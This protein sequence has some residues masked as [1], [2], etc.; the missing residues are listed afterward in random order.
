[1]TDYQPIYE[2]TRG[3][4]RE[5][6][7][8]GAGV[9]VSADGR[10]L[11]HFGNPS[12]LTY[13]RSTAK[14]FQALP[15]VE[16]G[17]PAALSFST[18]ELALI[19]ASHHGTDDHAQTAAG[20]QSRVG[21]GETEL[22]CGVHP[23]VDAE[24]RAALRARGE[25][26]QLNRHNCSGKHTGML[27]YSTWQGWDNISYLD[28]Q[29][30][31]QKNILAAFAEMCAV[32]PGDVELGIDGCSAPNFAI[33]LY[34][35][36]L[37]LARLADPTDLED[38]RQTACRQITTAMMTHPEMIAGPKGFDTRL[39]QALGPILAAKGGA[40]GYQGLAILPGSRLGARGVGIAF[41]ISDG[42]ARGRNRAAVALEVLR[43]LDVINPDQLDSLSD[44][45]PEL[46]IE[47][48]RHLHVGRG[49][50]LISLVRDALD[51]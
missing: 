36:A 20:I 9:V 42:D 30:P 2:L 23:P 22:Q 44:F 3:H 40:E 49:R 33:P 10:L 16:A 31:V 7:H 51:A 25:D 29:H 48:W 17:G 15:F 35:A 26:P 39:M 4:V 14:P 12:A 13:L 32:E 38:S 11:A 47:N 45:G 34:N 19:C 41:K 8:F 43:Q 28:I 37:G 5:S 46:V 1:M 21:F 18:K 24:T 27:S 50:P 6:V